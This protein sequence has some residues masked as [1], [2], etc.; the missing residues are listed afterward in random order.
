MFRNRT[1]EL[2]YLDRRYARDGAEFVVLYGRR[3]VGKSTLMYEWGKEEPM[4][5][6]FAAGAHTR[7]QVATATQG[8]LAATQ[9]YLNELQSIGAIE[10]RLPLTRVQSEKRQGTHLNAS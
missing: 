5:Y 8:T 1:R 10:H 7:Q 9:H 2:E 6:F 3:R 4:L